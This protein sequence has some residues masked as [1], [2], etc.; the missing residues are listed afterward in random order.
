MQLPILDFSTMAENLLDIFLEAWVKRHHT[1]WVNLHVSDV[2]AAGVLP[3]RLPWQDQVRVIHTQDRCENQ[4]EEQN[5]DENHVDRLHVVPLPSYNITC[6]VWIVKDGLS[7]TVEC[8][9]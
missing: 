2:G 8:Q 9:I 3:G 5:D 1:N 6:D 7:V 4:E